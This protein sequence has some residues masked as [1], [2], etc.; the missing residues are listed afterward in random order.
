MFFYWHS[1]EGQSKREE[2]TGKQ[3]RGSSLAAH[4]TE[5]FLCVPSCSISFAMSTFS[6]CPSETFLGGQCCLF[7]C[8][9]LRMPN[10]W[11]CLPWSPETSSL[12]S[13]FTSHGL[14]GSSTQ[15][16]V[17]GVSTQQLSLFCKMCP[18]TPLG[19]L[20]GFEDGG[21]WEEVI[22]GGSPVPQHRRDAFLSYR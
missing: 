1:Q 11:P 18:N 8:V 3:Y 9:A 15:Q 4:S 7:G 19:F 17:P 14:H 2:E 21:S 10:I 16:H 6:S 12:W 22:S 5:H 20:W 13:T